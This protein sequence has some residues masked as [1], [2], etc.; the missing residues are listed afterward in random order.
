MARAHI[1][2]LTHHYEVGVALLPELIEVVCELLLGDV[3]HFSQLAQHLTDSCWC[4]Q[5]RSKLA[6]DESIQQLG[7]VQQGGRT[8]LIVAQLEQVKHKVAI[9]NGAEHSQHCL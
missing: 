8:F 2:V 5:E 6:E 9:L 3:A 4:N 7:S 1:Q